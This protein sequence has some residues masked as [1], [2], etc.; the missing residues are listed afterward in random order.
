MMQSIASLHDKIFLVFKGLG[1]ISRQI[2]SHC[3]TIMAA[4]P[5]AKLSLIS[6]GNLRYLQ[7][8]QVLLHAWQVAIL[9]GNGPTPWK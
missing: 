8:C 4:T 2:A 3:N 9:Q 1:E 7:Y 6:L 5:S